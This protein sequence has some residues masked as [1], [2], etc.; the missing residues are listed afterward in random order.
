MTE[1]DPRRAIRR[2]NLVG[3][4]IVVLLLGGVGGWATTTQLAGAVIAPGTIVVESSI[5]KVQH[6]T[7]GV[8]G[9]ILVKEGD[10]VDEGQVVLRLDDTVTRSTLG[11]VRSQLDELLTR[12]AR[13]LAERDE[14]DALT[15]PAA[16]TNRRDDVAVATAFAGEQRLFESRRTARTG[17]RAQLRERIT[18]TNE[19]IRG[20]SAQQAAKE[21]E[22][23][24]IGKELIGVAELYQRNLVSIS[25]YMLLQR[26]QTKLQGERGQLIA[27]I[28]RARGKISE[29]ELQIIQLDQDFRT[30]V[31]KD[32][33]EAQ[34]KIAELK[35]KVTAAEDQLKR[36][37]LR[38]PQAGIVHQL[39]VHT[40][41]GVIGNGETIMQIVPRADELVLEAKV[42]PSDVDQVAPGA[43][44]VVRIM[45]GNQRTTP[46]LNGV[47]RRVSADLTREQQSNSNGQP[48]P[49]YYTVRIALP[50]DEVAR[51]TDIRLI[52]GMPAEAF[53]QTH[54]RTPLQYLLKP[55]R[56][57]IARTFRER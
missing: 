47:L 44:V 28:A 24:L 14:A 17:Q 36:I 42:T 45:A 55:L 29:T 56:E 49:A 23:E 18:Q 16:L 26:D 37:D 54:E 27:E 3:F 11:A 53:I 4:A 5:K 40:V 22:I 48:P 39:T 35:E 8:V 38:A 25:R 51:L 21:S 34:G 6:P 12:E 20:L 32:L 2:L 43:R 30:E 50:A 41:G 57:Q 33:R 15:F 52:P 10:T 13:L 19:E 7:G 31:L 1:L 9:E 46:D